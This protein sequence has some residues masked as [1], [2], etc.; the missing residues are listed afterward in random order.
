MALAGIGEFG[1]YNACLAHSD[2]GRERNEKPG[3][4]PKD[5]GKG[6]ICERPW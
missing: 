1:K 4:S 2:W 6:S 3:N 5:S